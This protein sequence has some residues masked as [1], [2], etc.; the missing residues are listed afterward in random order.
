MI[1]GSGGSDAPRVAPLHQL[2]Q[3]FASLRTTLVELESLSG[4]GKVDKAQL[5][6]LKWHAVV[7]LTATK[8]GIRD[9]F[10]AGDAWRS[11]VQEQKD[12]AEAHQLKLQNLLYEKDHLLREIR[13]CRGF[14]T[15]EMDKIEFA[16]GAIPIAVA[17]AV[18]RQHLDQLTQE[19]ETRKRMMAQ[20]KEIKARIEVV[21]EAT[22]RK[23]SFLD[24]L[25]GQLDRIE[26][27]TGGLQKYMRAP[28]STSLQRQQDANTQ[29][30][31]PL[32]TLYCE[33][34]AYQ[35]ASGCAKQMQLA[36]VDAKGLRGAQRIKKRDFPVAL[37]AGGRVAGGKDDSTSGGGGPLSKRQKVP[38]RSPS[39]ATRRDGGNAAKAPSRS[40]SIART[41]PVESGEVVDGS[42]EPQDEDGVI[43]EKTDTKEV[44]E[45]KLAIQDDGDVD[46]LTP[47]EPPTETQDLWRCSE[48]AVLLKLSLAI[49]DDVAGTETKA[50]ALLFQY[51]PAAEIVTAELMT[52]STLTRH[53]LT[54]LFPGDYGLHL[55]R[56][57]T[58]YKFA[59]DDSHAEIVFPVELTAS[60]PYYWAQWICGLHPLQR[61]VPTASTIRRPEPSVRNTMDQLIRRLTVSVQ[62][63]NHLS[64]LANGAAQAPVHPSHARHFPSE[65]KTTLFRW[66]EQLCDPGADGLDLV[67]QNDRDTS[68]GSQYFTVSFKNDKLEVA[69][70]V[71][72]TPE[73][74]VRAPRFRLRHVGTSTDATEDNALKEIEIEVNTFYDELV[75]KTCAQYLLAHQLR[76]VQHCVDVLSAGDLPRCFGRERRGKDRRP[77]LVVD[78]VTKEVRHR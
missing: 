43:V 72:V 55:P 58:A 40:P 9:T 78:P 4:S 24:G 49:D 74:P 75:D 26:D 18:H 2:K 76:K 11:R 31:T 38:S 65:I 45:V 23:Q 8:A 69:G 33:L 53:T 1:M 67:E 7:L 73:Y 10:L 12:I 44:R 64:L 20:V 34:E 59:S 21:E 46:M 28:V 35:S 39:V 62:L 6:Q 37:L 42:S 48:K 51:F 30:P 47:E 68:P 17:P 70:V 29:L 54:S 71:H 27:S 57:A 66:K 25:R 32:Y 61:V 19:L 3:A 56:N 60:R 5:K 50:F 77:A 15:K 63:K 41:R 13:R 14:S 52:P 22:Q 16:S 36:I